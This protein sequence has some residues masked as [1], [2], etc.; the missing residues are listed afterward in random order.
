VPEHLRQLELAAHQQDRS[1]QGLH[2][3][4]GGP[5]RG[6][7]GLQLVEQVVQPQLRQGGDH[8]GRAALGL[9]PTHASSPIMST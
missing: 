4:P 8:V 5:D 2:P 9:L 6:E 3:V 1:E 7:P